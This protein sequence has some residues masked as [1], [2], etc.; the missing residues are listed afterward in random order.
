MSASELLRQLAVRLG[1]KTE[2]PAPG[3]NL[4]LV[5]DGQLLELAIAPEDDALVLRM[6]LGDE[7]PSAA[8]QRLMAEQTL[9][10]RGTLGA[11][12]ALDMDGAPL[13]VR[14]LDVGAMDI[15]QLQQAVEN[16]VNTAEG[17]R[18][19]LGRGEVPPPQFPISAGMIRA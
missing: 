19:H 2:P 4:A 8:L 9:F 11:A 10:G 3:G 13:L 7:I 17:W 12:L 5:V 18:D 14:R 6:S 16:F 1:L 15:E